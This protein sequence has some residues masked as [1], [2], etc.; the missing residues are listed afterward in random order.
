MYVLPALVS[1]LLF[2][3]PS[4]TVTP[5]KPVVKNSSTNQKGK[6]VEKHKDSEDSP[7]IAVSAREGTPHAD[8]TEENYQDKSHGGVYM[9]HE[10]SPAQPQD[11]PLFLP[12]LIA[13]ILGVGI[14]A[15][16]S[17]LIWRQG[18]F[19]KS[20]LAEMQKAQTK[21]DALIVQATSQAD[22]A[23]SA[24][25]AAENHYQIMRNAE[26]PWILIEKIQLNKFQHSEELIVYLTIKN[27]G[28]TPAFMTEHKIIFRLMQ[29]VP[30]PPLE[31]SPFPR[32]FQQEIITP[33]A[34][35]KAAIRLIEERLTRT[36]VEDVMNRKEFLYVFGFI[37]YRDGAGLGEYETHF[38]HV[39]DVPVV[40]GWEFM[41]TGPAAYNQVK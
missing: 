28:R 29:S 12:Y 10:V 39:Y 13:T 7:G 37:K 4:P 27:Y 30:K 18:G 15:I 1:C 31:Y 23:L 20:Q 8:A 2:Q 5:E 32:E 36:Q 14:N 9:V 25:R 17:A 33:N 41:P 11:T 19:M 26:R 3:T 6:A 22:A 35:G 24:A 40:E 38:F 21:T 34:I 16:I